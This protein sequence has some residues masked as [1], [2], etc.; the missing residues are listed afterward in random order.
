MNHQPKRRLIEQAEANGYDLFLAGHTHGGQIVFPFPFYNLSGS[1]LETNYVNGLYDY[2]SIKV[3]ITSGLGV[4]IA[5][6]RYNAT[7]NIISIRLK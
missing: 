4:S 5:P 2:K 1:R 7:P 3:A 6:I